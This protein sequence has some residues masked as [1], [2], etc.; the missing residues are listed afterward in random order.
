MH[1][2]LPIWAIPC[3]TLC[4]QGWYASLRLWRLLGVKVNITIS[5]V[6]DAVRPLL[7]RSRLSI[8]NT[9]TLSVH[10]RTTFCWENNCVTIIIDTSVFLGSATHMKLHPG[11]ECLIFHTTHYKDVDDVISRL[12]E[13]RLKGLHFIYVGVELMQR[14][15]GDTALRVLSAKRLP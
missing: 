9:V 4:L 2:N 11:P 1:A 10:R 6:S 7:T 5:W 8:S 15:G 14:H 3:K 13:H 12:A